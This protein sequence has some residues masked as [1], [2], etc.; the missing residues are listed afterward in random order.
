MKTIRILRGVAVTTACFGMLVPQATRAIELERPGSGTSRASEDRAARSVVIDVSLRQ[1]G[2]L[3]GQ[4]VDPQG[5]AIEGA[6]VWL[7]QNGKTLG[8]T[9]ADQHGRFAMRGLRGGVYHLVTTSGSAI[10][11]AWSVGTAPPSSRQQVMLVS[12]PA[13]RAQEYESIEPESEEIVPGQS[14]PVETYEPAPGGPYYSGPMGPAFGGPT[15]G[16]KM[17]GFLTNPWVVG[18]LIAAAIAVPLAI[19]DDDN[20]L[21]S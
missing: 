16:Q 1:G 15:F 5:Q 2:T 21:A 7:R 11:R 18:A 8:R 3:S 17:V 20:D 14:V 19:D 12:G 13:I 6:N 9:V 4:V 10:C